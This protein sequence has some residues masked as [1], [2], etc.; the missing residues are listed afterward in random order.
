MSLP[1]PRAG[2]LG[3]ARRAAVPVPPGG[4]PKKAFPR[5]GTRAGVNPSQTAHRMPFPELS[6]AP[7]K[8]S[9]QALTRAASQWACVPCPKE[10]LP[11]KGAT[12]VPGW[13]RTK[14]FRPPLR[15]GS[16]CPRGCGEKAPAWWWETDST[17]S[18]LGP[19]DRGPWAQQA[20]PP[21]RSPAAPHSPLRGWSLAVAAP[22]LCAHW[23]EMVLCL[24]RI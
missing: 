3:A 21:S 20:H 15:R 13:I 11:E 19:W 2:G 6:G 1:G 16:G 18:A 10:D 14:R 7:A 24:S 9:G 17:E 5:T 4:H 8:Q 22:S 23:H 12:E